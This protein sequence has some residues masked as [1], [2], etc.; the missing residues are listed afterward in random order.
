MHSNSIPR[1]RHS[2]EFKA[3]VLAACEQPGASVSAVALAHGLN[4]NLVR[5]WRMGRGVKL[6]GVAAPVAVPTSAAAPP[7]PVLAADARFVPIEMCKPAQ[8]TP[9]GVAH[10]SEAVIHVELKRGTASVL[11]RWPGSAVGECATWLR[12]LSTALLK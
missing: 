1:R 3:E 5:K 10:C 12:E 7:R 6:A 11:V 4:T 9:P 2:A 8:A